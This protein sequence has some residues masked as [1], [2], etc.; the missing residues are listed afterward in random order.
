MLRET[1]QAGRPC[2]VAVLKALADSHVAVIASVDPRIRV[3]RVTDRTTWLTEAPD[4]EVIMGFR[5]LRDGALR[6]PHLR[7]VHAIGAGVEN[8]CQDVAGTEVQVT[9]SHIHGDTI[10]DHVFAF[11][12]AHTRRLREAQGF[13]TARQWVHDELRGTPLAGRTIGILGLGTIGAGVARRAAA[14]GM[15]VVGTKRRPTP[16]PGVERIVPPDEIDAVLREASVLAMTLPLTPA[17][18]G[19]LGA[20]ELALLPQGAFVVNIGRG[21]Q[22]DEA[23]L[24]EALRSGHLGGAGLDVF[25]DEPLPPDS[26][27][28]TAPGLMITPHV[29]GDFP[30]YMDRMLPLFCENLKQYLAGRPLRNVVD[31][32]LGY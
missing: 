32:A 2:T 7:W 21:G 13:Q 5:P 14:F 10:A 25:A 16:I 29:A 12:L 19:I 17:T 18:K 8:L 3:V 20:R 31:T 28:W 27:L 15:R 24:V 4:A 6:S 23:A 1:P 22:I 9:N 30:G 26:P 11:I